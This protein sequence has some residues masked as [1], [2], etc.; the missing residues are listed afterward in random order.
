MKHVIIVVK[1]VIF[2]FAVNTVIAKEHIHEGKKVNSAVSKAANCAPA[3]S[4]QTLQ[5]N[6]VKALIETGG[7]LWMDRSTGAAAYEVPKG[8]GKTA[9]FAG[10]L[11][12]GGTDENSQLRIAAVRFRQVGNDFWSGPLQENSATIDPDRCSEMDKFFLI[13]RKEVE[14][15]RA[16]WNAKCG[17]FPNGGW[18]DY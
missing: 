1:L 18:D 10:S 4:L 3:S 11:W 7:V 2:V 6:N 17:G 9:L 12:I 14:E 5:V 13:T 8:S 15:F 16:Y